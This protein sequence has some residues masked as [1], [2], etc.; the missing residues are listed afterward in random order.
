MGGL[1]WIQLLRVE[2]PE[3]LDELLADPA[4]APLL[5]PLPGAGTIAVVTATAAGDL[6]AVR[7]ALLAH[8]FTLAGEGG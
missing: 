7:A 5:Q 1:R 6:A 4:L 2:R 3:L 8:G